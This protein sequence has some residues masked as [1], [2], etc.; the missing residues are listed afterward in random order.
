VDDIGIVKAANDMGDG[1][2]GTDVPQELIAEA[3]AFARASD[4]S[5]DVHELHCGWDDPLRL[6]DGGDF[7]QTR[8]R[9]GDNADIGVNSAKRVIGCLGFG[10]G[11]R[12]KDGALSNVGQTNDPT[13]QRQCFLVPLQMKMSNAFCGW[14]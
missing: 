2:G 13:I 1:I 9:D 6:E 7:V 3:L 5:G 11:Q 4:E 12:I 14:E 8:V 10:R